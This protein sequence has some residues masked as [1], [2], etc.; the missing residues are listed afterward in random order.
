MGCAPS[1]YAEYSADDRYRYHGIL[2]Y[3]FK[4]NTSLMLFKK[5]NIRCEI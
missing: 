1:A 5:C 3:Y 2:S 4:E